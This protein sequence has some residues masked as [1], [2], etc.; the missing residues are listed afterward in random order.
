[1]SVFYRKCAGIAFSLGGFLL[2][3]DALADDKCPEPLKPV[4]NVDLPSRYKDDDKSRS[5][6]DEKLNAE[7]EKS[8]API[9]GFI[10]DLAEVANRT[11][12]E[13]K[14]DEAA[15]C[16][17]ANL[18]TWAK[19]EA[20]TQA[21]TMNA[22]L[23]LSSRIAG[24]AAAYARASTVKTPDKDVGPLIESWLGGLAEKQITFFDTEAPPMASRNN[25]RAWAG[26]AA[27]QVGAITKRQPLLDWGAQTNE[28]LICSANPDGSL[29]EEMKRKDKALHYQLHAVA[30]LVVTAQLLYPSRPEM[31][32]I[33]E[34]K[35]AKIVGFTIAALA[36][37]AM[38]A[39][40]ADAKQSFQTKKERLRAFQI[41]WL[42]PYLYLQNNDQ[43]ALDLAKKFRP[44]S[45]SFLGGN[46]TKLY[47]KSE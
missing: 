21:N 31:L 27:A 22:H 43:A 2:A 14:A 5:E 7:V 26:L 8:L 3:A 17:F 35:L 20:L 1:M 25:H 28:M 32:A 42:E 23:A 46:L 11:I 36:N 18:A 34:G 6:I 16:I 29:P 12:D 9:D 10:R 40:L 45:N 13:K 19:V 33:C 39:D 4:V 37:P 38:V 47:E 30:P 44:L 15:D 24:I 41:A